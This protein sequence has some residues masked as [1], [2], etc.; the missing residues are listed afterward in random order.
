MKTQGP[1]DG[2]LAFSQGGIIFRHFL[3]IT[4]E[5]DPEA[6][7]SPVDSTKQVFQMPK[8][9]MNVASPVFDMR[10]SYKGELFTQR[11]TVQFNFPSIHLHGT[12]DEFKANLTTHTLFDPASNPQVID[13]DEGHKFPRQLTNESFDKLKAFVK[14]RY[15]DKN[16][17]DNEYDVEYSEYN[18]QVRIAEEQKAWKGVLPGV[19]RQSILNLLTTSFDKKYQ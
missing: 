8:F 9:F 2:V 15:V 18:F 3:R 14:A 17:N 10:F 1:F 13:F 12:Q 19:W 16:G 7:V 5:I 11:T 6:F 4:Q